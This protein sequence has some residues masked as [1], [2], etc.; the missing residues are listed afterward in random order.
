MVGGSNPSGRARFPRG[1]L[2]YAGQWW[3][4]VALE[5]LHQSLQQEERFR[6]HVLP[7]H[8]ACQRVGLTESGFDAVTQA[9]RKAGEQLCLDWGWRA[10]TIWTL[11]LRA[12]VG[13]RPAGCQAVRGGSEVNVRTLGPATG[14][15]PR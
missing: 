10:E 3:P 5:S 15:G 6:S 9:G 12:W 13:S 2:A 11:I 8:R 14:L 1:R 4:T 7:D